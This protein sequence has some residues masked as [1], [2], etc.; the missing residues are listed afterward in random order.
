MIAPD[1]LLTGEDSEDTATTVSASPLS[2]G[3]NVSTELK[4][5]PVSHVN[6]PHMITCKVSY[7]VKRLRLHRA[8][9][10]PR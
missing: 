7:R 10:L 6:S 9:F 3:M 2:K 1:N 4:D 5:L 8:K